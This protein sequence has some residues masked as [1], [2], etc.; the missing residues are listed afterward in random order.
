MLD[1]LELASSHMVPCT[2]SRQTCEIADSGTDWCIVMG[3]FGVTLKTEDMLL[4]EPQRLTF[5][6]RMRGKDLCVTHMH[7]SNNMAAI[8]PDE[9]FPIKAS[10]AAYNY[11][12]EHISGGAVTVLASDRSLHRIERDAVRYLLAANE[13]M[14][15][16][17]ESGDIRVHQKLGAVQMELFPGFLVLHRSYCVNPSHLRT[18]RQFEAGLTDG[19]RLPVSRDRYATLC[20]QLGVRL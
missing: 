1:G 15:I 4:H 13:Y 20:E 14:V 18:I 12:V 3:N 7:V 6:W 11:F 9:D 5:V 17:S 16:H 10:R 2:V 8:E 19:T